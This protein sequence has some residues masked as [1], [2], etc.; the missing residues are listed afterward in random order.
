MN[1]DQVLEYLKE[2]INSC[3]EMLASPPIL[4]D[5][6]RDITKEIQGEVDA[7]IEVKAFI[8]RG[9]LKEERERRLKAEEEKLLKEKDLYETVKFLETY[10]E[11]HRASLWSGFGINKQSVEQSMEQQEAIEANQHYK[12][13]EV[14]IPSETEKDLYDTKNIISP[15][16]TKGFHNNK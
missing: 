6:N 9:I 8:N 16:E 1:I 14:I 5:S 11:T 7:Y 15:I 3:Y 4:T 12:F 13:G 2:Q 10:V